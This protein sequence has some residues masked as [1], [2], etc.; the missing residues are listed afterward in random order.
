M[1][2]AASRNE[3]AA[4]VLEEV[5][6]AYMVFDSEF[7]YMLF[8]REAER[9]TGLD[10]AKLIGQCV[11]DAHPGIL[12]TQIERAYRRA[13]AER[14]QARFE[15][16]HAAVDRWFHMQVD[17]MDG[18]LI[19]GFRDITQE[20]SL[21][22]E[23]AR[24]KDVISLVSESGL[25]G[26]F[27]WSIANDEVT[28]SP[29]MCELYGI[30]PGEAQT[31]PAFWSERL[32]P[33]DRREMASRL[34]ACFGA[35]ASSVVFDFR[36]RQSDGSWRWLNCRAKVQYDEHGKPALMVGINVNGTKQKRLEEQLRRRVEELETLMDVTPVPIFVAHDPACSRISGNRAANELYG[37]QAGEN[38]SS[39]AKAVR[40]F[41]RNG[42]EIAP[43][44]LPMQ[45]AAAR[46]IAIRDSELFIEMPRGATLHVFGHASPLRDA[47]GKARG[48]VGAFVDITALKQAE[49]GLRRE[50]A[51]LEATFQALQDGMVV[52]D[53]QRNTVLINEVAA[54]IFGFDS[55]AEMREGMDFLRSVVELRMP[56]GETIPYELRPASRALRGEKF[57]DLELLARR[58]DTGRE[59][60]LSFSAS[61]V[62]DA[63]GEQILAVL[64]I[65]DVTE[66]KLTAKALIESETRYRRFVESCPVGLGIGWIAGE[67]AGQLSFVNDAFLKIVG[68][69]RQE[70]DTGGLIRWDTITPQ[71]FEAADRAATAEV[72]EKGVA[73]P[74]EKE[75]IR[76]D[77]TRVP[78][79]LA[80]AAI[81][82]N[83]EVGAFV[84]DLAE[85][86]ETRRALEERRS[87]LARRVEE[88]ETLLSVAPVG[89]AVSQ[90]PLGGDIRANPMLAK[91]LG[92][93]SETNVSLSGPHAK[94]LP[95]RILQDGREMAPEDTPQKVAARTGQ[96]IG[97][98]ELEVAR[99]DGARFC[100]FGA[101]APLFAED[102]K[103]R[104]S[105]AAYFDATELRAADAKVR[106]SHAQLK[107]LVDSNIVGVIVSRGTQV[108]DANDLFL[109]MLGY[110]REEMIAG[111]VNWQQATAPDFMERSMAAVE[112]VRE[113][114]S[115]TPFEKEYI[116]RDGT[117][118]PVYLGAAILTREPELTSICFVVDLTAQKALERE[119][120]LANRRLSHS[121]E[122][123]QRF[124][125]VAAHDLQS[126]LRTIETMTQLLSRRLEGQLGAEDSEVFGHIQT[127]AQRMQ[128]LIADLLEYSRVSGGGTGGKPVDCAALLN[129][130]MENLQTRIRETEATVT[131][132]PLPAVLAGEQLLRVFQN[133]IDNALKYRSEAAPR[134]HVAAERSGEAWVIS[135]RDN[136]IGFDMQYADRIFRVFERLHGSGPHEG[137][138]IGLAIC[139][140][141]IERYGGRMWAESEPGAGST[142]FFS[143]P[144]VL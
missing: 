88:F 81:P 94:Q 129:G 123:L 89:I 124:A 86:R 10:R 110:S 26:S 82:G 101:A 13:A 99:A 92:A 114:G 84:L 43:S 79:L 20:K 138:G 24:S 56:G 116:R 97:P 36:A 119:L 4:L 118:V 111:Q 52:L 77:G 143:L 105:I 51:Q 48:S 90:D 44:E 42:V 6:H 17:P 3:F 23:L 104:G 64:M 131:A 74:Y 12:G 33:D 135:V 91:L 58:P 93:G 108:I 21:Q 76:K 31:A 49:Q 132:D 2:F 106:E 115:C 136:G 113:R 102:G 38:I 25:A 55:S 103:V 125:Y 30:A 126:P 72:L 141:L 127:S 7:R 54:R 62:Y 50:R 87:E 66:V 39:A 142:F 134:I 67:Q 40:R 137:T 28:A 47:T 53:M 19:V 100:L 29:E 73:Q 14:V 16:Y 34:E 144:A 75:Y 11:W 78:V 35:Q 32:H 107:R 128:A 9:L 120:H 130:A 65:R 27:R 70:F 71:E 140:K 45:V 69:T 8:N 59:W 139:R 109:S 5:R 63:S 15:Y 98:V 122:E 1:A 85:L 22:Q 133:L 117:R 18:G 60:S 83:S 46:N 95:F 68:Y 112:E 80:L 41:F 121:N 96:R 37:T 61:P 57:A